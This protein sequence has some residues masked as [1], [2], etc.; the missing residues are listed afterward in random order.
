MPTTAEDAKAG[1][2]TSIV[3]ALA[4]QLGAEITVEGADPGTVVTLSRVVKL[5]RAGVATTAEAS[6]PV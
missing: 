5:D 1:L 4:G 3:K 6:E 2:G